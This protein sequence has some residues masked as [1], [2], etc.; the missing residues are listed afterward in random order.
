LNF[1]EKIKKLS[2]GNG[3][4]VILSE[5]GDIYTYGDNNRK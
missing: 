4:L 2:A 3:F 1:Q 5:K